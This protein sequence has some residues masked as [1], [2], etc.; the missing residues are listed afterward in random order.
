MIEINLIP[1][2]L[3]SRGLKP[4]KTAVNGN[5]AKQPGPQALILLIPVIFAVLII[6][7]IYLIFLGLTR[8]VHLNVLK[9]RWENSL[10]QRKALEE[11]D[12]E[13]SLVSAGAKETQRLI[14]ERINWSEALN[15]LS[16]SL[17][18]GI[19]LESISI[20]GKEFY[21]R[22]KAVSLDKTEVSLIRNYVDGIKKQ[23]NFMKNFN[24]LEITSIQKGAIG[25]YEVTDFSLTG[26]YK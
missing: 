7:H 12:A 2:E 25:A 3:R 8:S 24:S 10:P 18:A 5:L 9:A 6:A 15:K 11:F 4:V 26:S 14:S 17:P 21:L 19:W 20:S 1:E 22:G 23:P 13:H 16:L